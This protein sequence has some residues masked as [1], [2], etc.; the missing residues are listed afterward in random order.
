MTVMYSENDDQDPVAKHEPTE[1]EKKQAAFASEFNAMVSKAQREELENDDK[2]RARVR[3]ALANAP[4]VQS[5]AGKLD[6]TSQDSRVVAAQQSPEEYERLRA[7]I[8]WSA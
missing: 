8:D 3:T 4:I 7:E 5:L 1:Y 6:H 2:D